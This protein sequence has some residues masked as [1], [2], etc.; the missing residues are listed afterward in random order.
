MKA[1][2]LTTPR[3]KQ[4]L[5]GPYQELQSFHGFTTFY[6]RFIINFSTIAAPL[7]DSMKKGNFHWNSEQ[8]TSFEILKEK[9]SNTPIL[10]IPDFNKLFEVEVDATR[11]GIE[12]VLS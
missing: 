11:K 10:A 5:T 7:T 8:Q 1:S 9:L 4:L 2:K 6:R 12:A 3:L